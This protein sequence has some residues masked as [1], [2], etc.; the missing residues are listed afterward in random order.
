MRSLFEPYPLY[1]VTERQGL[2][3]WTERIADDDWRVWLFAPDDAIT[4][5]QDPTGRA[6]RP[7]QEGVPIPPSEAL[8]PDRAVVL[9]VRGLE[10][11]EPMVT[12]LDAIEGLAP[13]ATLVQ[14]NGRVPRFPLPQ[15]EER[16]CVYRIRPQHPDLVRVFITRKESHPMSA[17]ENAV[18][19]VRVI[20]PRDKHPTIFRTFDALAE[21]EA[22]VLVND[23]DPV[24]LRYQFQHERSNLFEW[25]YMEEGPE[26]WRV[27]IGRVARG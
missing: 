18:L 17:P 13:G 22:F 6:L 9:D 8:F 5:G 21:G 24:P 27:R 15:L 4:S 14:V 16:V 26:V 3:H 25:S 10:P 11:P 20:P 7:V 1:A 12:T 23:H 2:S 19:D